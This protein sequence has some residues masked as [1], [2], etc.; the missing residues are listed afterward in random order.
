MPFRFFVHQEEAVRGE[1]RKSGF[2][3]V[4]AQQMFMW[5]VEVYRRA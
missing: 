5:N 3:E 2:S 4:F 1:I